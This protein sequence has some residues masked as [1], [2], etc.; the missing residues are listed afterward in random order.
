MNGSQKALGF[1]R[2]A[3]GAPGQLYEHLH[4]VFLVGSGGKLKMGS[5]EQI[6]VPIEDA[7]DNDG[8]D[9]DD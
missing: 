5:F 8:D 2:D 9:D 1:A 6:G 3:L 4:T 7:A